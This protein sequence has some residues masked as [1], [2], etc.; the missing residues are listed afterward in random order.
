MTN[1]ISPIDE[2]GAL[3]AQIAELQARADEISRE[4]K[5]QGPGRYSGAYFDANVVEQLSD[6]VDYK[7]IVESLELSPHWPEY[8]V[9]QT[10][11]GRCVHGHAYRFEKVE[12]G[13]PG[14]N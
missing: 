9:V 2:L 10:S 5:D 11:D 12:P 3:K 14:T 7:R 1:F 4:L 13:D 6:R 8:W